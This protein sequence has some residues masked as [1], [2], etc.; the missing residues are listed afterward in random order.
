MPFTNEHPLTLDE[1]RKQK[2]NHNKTKVRILAYRFSANY[3][4]YDRHHYGFLEQKDKGNKVEM[5]F[6]IPERD[7]GFA[8]WFLMYADYAQ[9][10]KLQSLKEKVKSILQKSMELI[11]KET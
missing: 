1:Y 11:Y 6:L 5:Q 10:V 4:Q 2:Q 7:E 8:R 9:I 3:L